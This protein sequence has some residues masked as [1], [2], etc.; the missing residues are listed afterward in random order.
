MLG[1]PTRLASCRSW[2][3]G[4]RERQWCAGRS[5]SPVVPCFTPLHF[6]RKVPDCWEREKGQTHA[7]KR[8][9]LD[10]H[11]HA[12]DSSRD[13]KYDLREGSGPDR[14]ETAVLGRRYLVG[15]RRGER[16]GEYMLTRTSK[17]RLR[18][19]WR[20][21]RASRDADR[22][23]TWFSS[24]LTGHGSRPALEPFLVYEPGCKEPDRLMRIAG[25]AHP[26]H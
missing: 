7:P 10:P 20:D 6:K 14:C 12:P 24:W 25:L 3:T 2:S 11:L 9:A 22:W 4:P 1:L 5:T 17:R 8:L 16:V 26:C 23:P 13:R 18:G 21:S 19:R 15:V